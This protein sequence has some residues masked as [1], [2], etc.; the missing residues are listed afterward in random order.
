MSIL[1]LLKTIG[2]AKQ[3]TQM[4]VAEPFEAINASNGGMI[5]LPPGTLLQVGVAN[6]SNGNSISAVADMGGRLQRVYIMAEQYHC[7]ALEH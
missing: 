5:L 2:H 4:L 7:L 1:D 6:N 3:G